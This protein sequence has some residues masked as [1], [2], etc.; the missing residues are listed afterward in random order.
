MFRTLV[1]VC[2]LSALVMP[3]MA[4]VYK[5]VDEKGMTH[6]GERPPQGGKA[7]ELQAG[8][9]PSEPPPG[10]A[11]Q[12]TWQEKERDF[13]QRRIEARQAEVKAKQQAAALRA[14]CNQERDQIAQLKSAGRVYHLDDNGQRVFESEVE[15]NASIARRE[16][17]VT[18]RC[19]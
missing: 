16:Q 4:Q 3:A 17:M 12:S 10:Q 13:Q 14:A 5:W 19:R 1:K 8:Q 9:A 2:V 18:E 11:A 7:Q 15:R 6:Y